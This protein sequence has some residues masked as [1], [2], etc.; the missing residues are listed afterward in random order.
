VTFVNC[1]KC[2]SSLKLSKPSVVATRQNCDVSVGGWGYEL[3]DLCCDAGLLI[4][5][6]RTPSDQSGEFICLAN[7]GRITV[8]DI[9]G[10]PAVWQAATH[11]EVI[12]DDIRYRAMGGDSDHRSLRL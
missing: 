4:L 10:S 9:V 1:Y 3:L 2:L 5:N 12:I 11:L 8:D 6:G 7:G